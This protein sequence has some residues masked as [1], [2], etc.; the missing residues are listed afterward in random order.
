MAAAS[1][2]M[3][4]TMSTS[5]PLLAPPP[6]AKSS[7]SKKNSTVSEPQP[8]KGALSVGHGK[9]AQ[10]A[11]AV[12]GRSAGT[13]TGQPRTV[14]TRG[15]AR[16]TRSRVAAGPPVQMHPD[17]ERYQE[18]QKALAD[19]G[20]FKGDANGQWN[21]DSVDAL[22]RFQADRHL[23]DDGKITALT[24]QGLGLGPKHD[25]STARLSGG[26]GGT[27]PSA[28]LPPPPQ[29]NPPPSE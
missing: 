20:Y 7:T 8:H 6:A 2:A 28:T 16:R 15:K 4:A 12:H 9:P 18:I 22:K 13:G 1:V 3:L 19:R 21:D 23:D 11:A 5:A 24:L 27:T 25:G 29:E 14:A 17:P 10:R 26:G